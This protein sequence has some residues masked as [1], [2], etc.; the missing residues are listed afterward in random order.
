MAKAKPVQVTLC[1]QDPAV[2]AAWR[3]QF[4]S[5]FDVRVCHGNLLDVAADAYVSPANGLGWMDGGFDRVLSLRFHAGDIQRRVSARITQEGGTLPVGRAVVVETGDELVPYLVVAPT[6]EVPSLVAGTDNA[7]R[8]MLALLRAVDQFNQQR[9]DDA[10]PIRRIAIAGLCTG[11]G[12]MP[13]D[14]AAEQMFRAY[15][16]WYHG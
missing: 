13:P 14:V 9:P 15:R 2:A 12:G 4:S 16:E 10:R 11:V 5:Y 8:A 6:M 3:A 7:Y 1:D